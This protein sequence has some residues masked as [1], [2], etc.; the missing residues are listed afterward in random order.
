[1]PAPYAV[2]LR[3]KI[4]D[5]CARGD[6]TQL[7]VAR[8]VGVSIS[9]VEK[10][11]RIY[12]LTGDLVAPRNTPGPHAAIGAQASQQ[13]RQWVEEQPDATLAELVDKLHLACGIEVSQAT[14]C[15]A[16]GRLGLRRKKRRFMPQSAM[17]P[18]SLRPAGSTAPSLPPAHRSV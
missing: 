6:V 13:L 5:A 16:L 4:V 8:F 12:R 2:D 11:L 9:F 3:R 1:M 10:L 14:V 15:R 17:R 18:R 7:E